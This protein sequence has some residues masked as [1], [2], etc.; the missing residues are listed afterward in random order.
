MS[1]HVEY[2]NDTS[3]DFVPAQWPELVS[4]TLFRIYEETGEPVF[5]YNNKQDFLA[6]SDAYQVT[7]SGEDYWQVEVED[8]DPTYLQEI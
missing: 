8:P 3:M 2:Y 6:I 4:G 5:N 7:I 1:R